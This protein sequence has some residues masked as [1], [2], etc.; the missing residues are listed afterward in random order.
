[1]LH[2]ASCAKE[3]RRPSL[4]CTEFRRRTKG[5]YAFRNGFRLMTT[6]APGLEMQLSS[7]PRYRWSS[8]RTGKVARRE[9]VHFGRTR[10]AMSR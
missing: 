10:H 8:L 4:G 1:M 9:L 2:W 6:S 5:T 7:E 3:T